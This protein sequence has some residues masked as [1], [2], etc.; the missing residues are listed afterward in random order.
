MLTSMKKLATAIL[1]M[2]LGFFAQAQ[3]DSVYTEI[4]DS[5]DHQF[6]QKWERL[7]S[8]ISTDPIETGYFLDRAINL[9]SP[10]KHQGTVNSDGVA[11]DDS[12]YYE[13]LL[14]LHQ[15]FKMAQ[16]DTSS[17]ILFDSPF[18]RICDAWLSSLFFLLLKIKY[19]TK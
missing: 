18:P 19:H 14:S 11:T 6:P 8:S 2:F 12:C 4:Y 10:A 16:I 3:S 1:L 9:I 15:S 13:T 5:T 17:H 7:F